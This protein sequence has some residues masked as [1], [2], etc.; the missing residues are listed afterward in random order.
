M[1]SEFDSAIKRL[2][3]CSKKQ[4]TN[5]QN[6]FQTR[7]AKFTINIGNVAAFNSIAIRRRKWCSIMHRA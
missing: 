6:N 1:K 3:K 2:L 4:K 7:E 5:M